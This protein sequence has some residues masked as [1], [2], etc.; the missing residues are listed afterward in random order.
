MIEAKM[1]DCNKIRPL[2][3]NTYIMLNSAEHEICPANKSQIIKGI[4]S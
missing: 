4:F 3:Y 1:P 2:G